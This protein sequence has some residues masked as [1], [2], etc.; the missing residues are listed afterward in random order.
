MMQQI[1]CFLL[2]H[3]L[4]LPYLVKCR[5]EAVQL[6]IMNVSSFL[7]FFNCIISTLKEWMKEDMFLAVILVCNS[8]LFIECVLVQPI[9]DM[10]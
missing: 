6:Y 1:C 5:Q 3:S 7:S 9:Y 4:I 2:S 10:L 8:P